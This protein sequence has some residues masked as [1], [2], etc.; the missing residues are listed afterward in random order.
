VPVKRLGVQDLFGESGSPEA[1][2]ARHGLDAR[3]IQEAVRA[4]C[5]ATPARRA[6]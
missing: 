2:Y 4:F 6:A 3:G 1:L 5:A